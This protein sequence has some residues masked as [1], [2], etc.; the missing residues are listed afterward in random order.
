MLHFRRTALVQYPFLQNCTHFWIFQQ[1][2]AHFGNTRGF[3][4]ARVAITHVVRKTAAHDVERTTST[5]T[6]SIHIITAHKFLVITFL[7]HCNTSSST[8]Q[9][10]KAGCT[11]VLWPA[12]RRR[13]ASIASNSCCPQLYRRSRSSMG[14]LVQILRRGRAAVRRSWASTRR[15]VHIRRGRAPTR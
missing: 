7:Q 3:N 13:R 14:L 1:N 15:N 8:R 12:F 6:T 4:S 11:H 9:L 5:H 2:S 10:L